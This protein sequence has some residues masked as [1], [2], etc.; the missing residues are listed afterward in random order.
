MS[1][2]RGLK[3]SSAH[4][5]HIFGKVIGVCIWY[6]NRSLLTKRGILVNQ[7]FPAFMPE[8]IDKSTVSECQALYDLE[9]HGHFEQA[10]LI[11]CD[12]TLFSVTRKLP[13][14]HGCF[15]LAGIAA[16]SQPIPAS[17]SLPFGLVFCMKCSSP[18]DHSGQKR[19]T[20][21]FVRLV[22]K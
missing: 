9:N 18:S 22:V 6:Q 2:V 11:K 5:V 17:P 12:T 10:F 20:C 21:Q 19:N 3:K 15:R 8:N 7:G 4:P 14:L 16:K 13:C 1:S